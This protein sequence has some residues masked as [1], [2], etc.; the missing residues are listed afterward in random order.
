M[1]GGKRTLT[2]AEAIDGGSQV[3]MGGIAQ[4]EGKKDALELA[5]GSLTTISVLCHVFMEK[6][7]LIFPPW[8]IEALRSFR[9]GSAR[10]ATCNANR[11]SR[12]RRLT[13]LPQPVDHISLG[14]LHALRH[15]SISKTLYY[16]DPLM[17]ISRT[18]A[19]L[20]KKMH[21]KQR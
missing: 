13:Y 11:G 17:S 19:K 12:H 20:Q 2:P 4:L 1:S 15:R 8:R 10:K 3:K 14:F 16:Q 6:R 9:S 18:T 21:Y 7:G 5:R